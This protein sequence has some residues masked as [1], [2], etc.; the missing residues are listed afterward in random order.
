MW[1]GN[2]KQQQ[3]QQQ[4]LT[5]ENTRDAL[6]NREHSETVTILVHQTYNIRNSTLN[7]PSPSTSPSTPRPHLNR[8]HHHH[9]HHDLIQ[10][11]PTITIYTMT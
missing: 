10:T 11:G 4:Q 2:V 5:N 7:P 8:F 6:D 3:Q 1:Q 9:Q